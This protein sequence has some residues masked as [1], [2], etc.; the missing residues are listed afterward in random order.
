M[1]WIMLT[2]LGIVALAAVVVVY[3]AYPYR[4]ERV[5]KAGWVGDAL[6]KGVEKLPTVDNA[7]R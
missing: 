2:M 1:L 5:P 7:R 6:Q 4:G 3:V